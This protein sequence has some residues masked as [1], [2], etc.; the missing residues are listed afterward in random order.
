M[1]VILRDVSNPREDVLLHKDKVAAYWEKDC[2]GQG[3]LFLTEKNL[4]WSQESTNKG[5]SISYL[6]VCVHAI[7]SSNDDFSDPCLF[8]MVDLAKTDVEYLREDADI[9]DA[10]PDEVKSITIRFVPTDSVALNEL[11]T[12]MNRCQENES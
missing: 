2:L 8:M 6:A 9:D 5:F 11:Y 10:D 1:P 7:S 12:Q 3:S 4:L